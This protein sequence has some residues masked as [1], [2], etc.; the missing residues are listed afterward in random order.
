MLGSLG[1]Q[2]SAMQ[3][4]IDGMDEGEQAEQRQADVH[5][6]THAGKENV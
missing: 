1:G 4:D 5:L 6:Q 2:S 3:V